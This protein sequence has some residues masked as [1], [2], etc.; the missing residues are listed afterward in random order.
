MQKIVEQP[1]AKEA[2]AIAK[3][4]SKLGFNI[5]LLGSEKYVLRKLKSLK[6]E[7]VMR[8]KEAFI[9]NKLP[10]FVKYFFRINHMATE[11]LSQKTYESRLE[12]LAHL[13]KVCGLLLQTKVYLF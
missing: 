1:P 6:T 13:I 11:T 5:Q 9:H 2:L 8:T 7:D 4:L 12:R 10:R 3:M